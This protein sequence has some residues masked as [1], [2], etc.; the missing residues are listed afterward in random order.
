[1]SREVREN[2]RAAQAMYEQAV[3]GGLSAGCIEVSVRALGG[4]SEY[5]DILNRNQN[6]KASEWIR[7][8]GQKGLDV[9]WHTGIPHDL[10]T[11]DLTALLCN[12]WPFA[13]APP[14]R[15]LPYTGYLLLEKPHSKTKRPR[16]AIAIMA[17]DQ[18]PRDARRI[19]KREDS[20]LV[21]DGRLGGM[22]QQTT[23][24]IVDRIHQAQD[25]H[26][27]IELMQIGKNLR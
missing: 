21:V 19:L 9:R 27:T 7:F 11:E 18:L 23:H 1:M 4:R 14:K 6:P 15:I 24:E 12:P 13:S 3:R 25:A 22:A 2:L 20:F 26:A 5:I 17:C 8:L 16:H 10:S